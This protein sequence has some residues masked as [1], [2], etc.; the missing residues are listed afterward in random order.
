MAFKS[1]AG[2]KTE[3][4]TD[5]ILD[6]LVNEQKI[7]DKMRPVFEAAKAKRL[8]NILDQKDVSLSSVS[9]DG[10]ITVSPDS[11]I[12]ELK[13]PPIIPTVPR[14]SLTRKQSASKMASPY[15]SNITIKKQS[16][17]KS[18]VFDQPRH[19]AP[20]PQRS[21]FKSVSIRD[22]SSESPIVKKKDIAHVREMLKEI[23]KLCAKYDLGNPDLN[24]DDYEEYEVEE[25]LKKIKRKVGKKTKLMFIKKSIISGAGLIEFANEN[26]NPLNLDLENLGA[27]ATTEVDSYEDIFKEIVDK[28]FSAEGSQNFPIWL[29]LGGMLF[30]SGAGFYMS[31]KGNG[32]TSV[33]GQNASMAREIAKVFKDNGSGDDM[34]DDEIDNDAILAHLH[35]TTAKKKEVDSEELIRIQEARRELDEQRRALERDAKKNQE[36]FFIQQR[37]INEKLAQQQEMLRRSPVVRNT[38]QPKVKAVSHDSPA[39]IVISDDSPVNRPSH[40]YNEYVISEMP[41]FMTETQRPLDS[42]IKSMDNISDS[43]HLSATSADDN[44]SIS[45]KRGGKSIRL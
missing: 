2:L 16:P 41:D 6:Y 20:S 23:D 30:M 18:K 13:L 39:N 35:K 15:K 27:F 21:K 26:F 43:I 45:F 14:Q 12:N 4:E 8:D 33:V 19:H 9:D 11:P 1:S 36:M 7:N 28:Y 31:K 32:V 22:K 37:E 25:A 24:E 42:L 3:A 38:P 34:F 29:R 5:H 40:N 17:Y 10:K 44:R